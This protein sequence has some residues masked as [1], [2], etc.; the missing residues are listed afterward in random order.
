M[1]GDSFHL[2]T[3]PM[4]PSHALLHNTELDITP[5]GS[6]L[7]LSNSP[8]HPLTITLV[9][10]PNIACLK[11]ICCCNRN[12]SSYQ[13]STDRERN[14][15]LRWGSRISLRHVTRQQDACFGSQLQKDTLENP[16]IFSLII[17]YV[18]NIKLVEDFCFSTTNE[19]NCSYNLLNGFASWYLFIRSYDTKAAWF[20]QHMCFRSCD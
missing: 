6:I 8:L 1:K 13:M 20:L 17:Q 3:P 18:S 14:T 11:A 15:S 4:N 10:L 7:L 19:H 5:R 16:L 9:L 2:S 12:Y